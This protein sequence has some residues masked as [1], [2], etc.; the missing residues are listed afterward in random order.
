MVTD[1]AAAAA[2]TLPAWKA[3]AQPAAPMEGA[4]QLAQD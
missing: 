1:L 3:L 2:A 4:Y